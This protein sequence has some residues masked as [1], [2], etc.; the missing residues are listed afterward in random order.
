MNTRIT[1]VINPLR[2]WVLMSSVNRLPGSRAT[3]APMMIWEVNRPRN[4]GAWRKSRHRSLY[5]QGLGDCVCGRQG[6]HRGGQH[7]RAEQAEREQVRPR[8][9]HRSRALAASAAEARAP[10]PPMTAAVAMMMNTR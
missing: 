1:G 4:R 9:G 6:H 7:R 8:P 3:A 5:S 10:V 2:T